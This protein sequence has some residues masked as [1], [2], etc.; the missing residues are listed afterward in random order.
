MR[1]IF[2]W[3]FVGTLVDD[4]PNDRYSFID[5]CIYNT[6]TWLWCS[7]CFIDVI[8]NVWSCSHRHFLMLEFCRQLGDNQ[9]IVLEVLSSFKKCVSRVVSILFK[10]CISIYERNW[11]FVL[12]CSRSTLHGG[13]RGEFWKGLPEMTYF[14]LMVR[15]SFIKRVSRLVSI[16]YKRPVS[17]DERNRPFELQGS[18]LTCHG[19]LHGKFSWSPG[20][21][22]FFELMLLFSLVKRVFQ[23][24]SILCKR[25]VF[26]DERNWPLLLRGSRSTCHGGCCG[27]FSWSPGNSLIFALMM[28]FSFIKRM[29]RL[30]SIL[31]KRSVSIDERNWP[32]LLQGSR[33]TCHGGSHC[34]FS[35]SPENDL[36]LC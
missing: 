29:F 7:F 6:G 34:E 3:R 36:F 11:P 14:F 2:S 31:C 33:S 17:I 24:A 15:F 5:D 25:F 20:N 18:R 32:L 13:C 4:M 9:F 35:W 26:I 16:F 30:V 1:G 12:Q 22:L 27:E 10:R 28:L 19:G 23:L 21:G 8:I